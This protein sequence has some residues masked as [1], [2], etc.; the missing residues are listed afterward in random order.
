MPL[1][2]HPTDPDKLVYVRRVYALAPR[3]WRGLTDKEFE[4][5][6]MSEPNAAV[7]VRLWQLIQDKLR[8]KNT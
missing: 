7:P 6:I 4:E 2:P 8:E 1:K 5:I 3:E